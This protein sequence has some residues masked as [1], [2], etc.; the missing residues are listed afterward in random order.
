MDFAAFKVVRGG[1]L[2]PPHHCWRQDLNLVRLPISP[3]ARSEGRIVSARK[4][5][6]EH[7]PQSLAA[8]KILGSAACLFIGLWHD[9]R[10][11]AI[12]HYENFPV[13]SWL[14]PPA[15]RPAVVALYRFARTAD[16]LA[17]EGD[18][19]ASQ[20]LADLARY[21]L[22]LDAALALAG[23]PAHTASALF[24]WPQV[25]QPLAMQVRQHQLP[26]QPLHA[27]LDAFEQD[28]HY[29]ASGRGYASMDELMDYCAL[30]ANPV[31]RLILHLNQIDH[32]TALAQ[33]D[34]ICSALQLINFW[35]DL[36]IDLP[37]RR[38]Y[39]PQDWLA[40]YEVDPATLL[41]Q[42]AGEAAAEMVQAL[43]QHARQLMTQ[44]AAL[45]WRLPGRTG[46]E[47]RLVVHGGLR[48]LDKIEQLRGATWRQRPKLSRTDFPLL[49][50]RA[51]H[52]PHM[53]TQTT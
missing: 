43:S 9:R 41:Q 28:V 50:W 5:T 39:L 48:I 42:A 8:G 30:S 34:A 27:L 45:A 33:S 32:P 52:L 17:D 38:C 29:T 35:Q 46:W 23:E 51:M 26:A 15:L 22:D 36:G 37:R 16:D 24:E 1:G 13:A 49:L 2:E 53:P 31:G 6:P 3:P 47:L 4:H 21:R 20:R 11:S 7:V 44:G 12:N 25:F 18:A 19:P 14:C 40:R 10:M